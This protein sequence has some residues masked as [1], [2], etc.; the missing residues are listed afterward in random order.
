MDPNATLEEM[1]T[2][3]AKMR[4]DYEDPDGN[5]IDQDDAN[6]LAELVEAM[7]GWLSK[8]GFLPAAWKSDKKGLPR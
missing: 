1:R 2:L 4:K 6:R 8:G 5:G 7:D 3:S